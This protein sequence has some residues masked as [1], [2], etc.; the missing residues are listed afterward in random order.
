MRWV[1]ALALGVTVLCLFPHATA[2]EQHSATA[3]DNDVRYF[4]LIGQ[5]YRLHLAAL[6]HIVA[7]ESAYGDNV[8]RHARAIDRARGLFDHAVLGGTQASSGEAAGVWPWKDERQYREFM[9]ANEVAAKN[10]VDVAREWRETGDPVKLKAAIDQ[11][12]ITCRVCHL[13]KKRDWP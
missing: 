12:K 1:R 2:A 13:D 6:E 9:D 3:T 10:L 7:T 4:N 5:I 11:V 8:V